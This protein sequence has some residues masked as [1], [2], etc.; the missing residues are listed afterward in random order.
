MSGVIGGMSLTI[1]RVYH[2]RPA[3]DGKMS[4]SPHVHAITDEAY[5][6]TRGRGAVEMHD[7]RHGYRVVPLEPGATITFPPHVLHRIVS[8]DSLEVLALIAHAGLAERGDARIYFGRLIDEDPAAFEELV[9]APQREGLEGA[10]RRR[11]RAVEAY[12]HLLTLWTTDRPAYFAE[13]ERFFAVHDRAMAARADRL[14]D[15]VEAGAGTAK[16][17]ALSRIAGLGWPG[18]R[19]ETVRA[20]DPHR[21]PDVLGMCGHLIQLDHRL[22]AVSG[23]PLR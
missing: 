18:E 5:F 2:E 21:P 23:L 15:A 8:E 14:R 13:L 17:T 3:P 19:D 7:L 22:A 16:Q 4:G 10:L 12:Q 6:V 11:D 1:V 9:S 20:I